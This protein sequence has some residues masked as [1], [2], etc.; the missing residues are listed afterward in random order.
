MSIPGG[1]LLR[2]QPAVHGTSDAAQSGLPALTMIA[3]VGKLIRP[4]GT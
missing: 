3:L 1:S 4:P 2:V